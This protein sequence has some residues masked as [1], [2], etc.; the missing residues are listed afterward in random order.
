MVPQEKVA[1]LT[2]RIDADIRPL[3]APPSRC[4]AEK[5]S[6]LGARLILPEQTGTLGVSPFSVSP[7]VD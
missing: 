2:P 6:T 1:S 5:N 4:L 7:L 3:T